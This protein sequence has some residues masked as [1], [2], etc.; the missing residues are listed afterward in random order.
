[1]YVFNLFLYLMFIFNPPAYD[2]AVAAGAPCY[3]FA[4]QLASVAAEIGADTEHQPVCP[5]DPT[6]T[7]PGK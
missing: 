3:G 2:A 4:P 6:N 1:M 7:N 5:Y